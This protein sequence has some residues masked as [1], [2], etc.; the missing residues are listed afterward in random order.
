M[1]PTIC[2]DR[3]S[4]NHLT[5]VAL[6][7]SLASHRFYKGHYHTLKRVRPK[8]KRNPKEINL[9][10]CKVVWGGGAVDS[11]S[12]PVPPPRINIK[13]CKRVAASM[14]IW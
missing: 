1:S 6:L 2:P 4:A 10:K 14:L 8:K 12:S 11:L 5:D 3:K 9:K 13:A 7:Y